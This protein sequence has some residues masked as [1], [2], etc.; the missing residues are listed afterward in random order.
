MEGK[1][2]VFWPQFCFLKQ[3]N[4]VICMCW[5]VLKFVTLCHYLFHTVFDVNKKSDYLR[6]SLGI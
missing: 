6:I 3:C 1:E 2:S 4:F 5:M